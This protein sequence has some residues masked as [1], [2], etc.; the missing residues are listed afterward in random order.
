M[1]SPTACLT[2][3]RASR[4]MVG[5]SSTRRATKGAG[6]WRRCRSTGACSSVFPHARAMRASRCGRHCGFVC[7]FGFVFFFFFVF[8]AVFFVFVVFGW[9]VVGVFV[10]VVCLWFFFCV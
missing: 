2:C 6:Y 5:L 1:S 10:V 8:G 3:R 7:C 9:F 4:P